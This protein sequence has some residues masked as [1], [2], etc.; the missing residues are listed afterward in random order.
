VLELQASS[1]I[2]GSEPSEPQWGELI[3]HQFLPA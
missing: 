2:V 3:S 1:E